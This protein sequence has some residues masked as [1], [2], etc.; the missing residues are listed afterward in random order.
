M[1]PVVAPHAGAWIETMASLTMKIQVQ[2]APHAGAWIETDAA[3][4]FGPAYW[5]R[6][7]QARGLKQTGVMALVRAI[8]VAPHAGA[9]IE[10]ATGK[11]SKC[12]ERSRLTQARGLKHSPHR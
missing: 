3:T 10:T 2:V 6:L 8:A 4:Q 9:W 1:L 5:S 7:T 12:S 11:R